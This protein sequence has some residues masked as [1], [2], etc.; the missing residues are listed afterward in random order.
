MTAENLCTCI[1]PMKDFRDVALLMILQ[2]PRLFDRDVAAE[3]K[4]IQQRYAGMRAHGW[5]YKIV[6]IYNQRLSMR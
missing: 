4:D 5:I 3:I 6:V 2:F 1:F